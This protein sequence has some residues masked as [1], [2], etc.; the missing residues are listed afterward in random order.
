MTL[1]PGEAAEDAAGAVFLPLF[2]DILDGLGVTADFTAAEEVVVSARFLD[3]FIK[4]FARL[5]PFDAGFYER[6]YRDIAAAKAAGSLAD[7]RVHFINNGFRENRMPRAPL[8]DA[9]YYVATYPDL[10]GL[11]AADGEAGLL[12]HYIRHGR[13]ERRLAHKAAR[14]AAE[15]W[16]QFVPLSRQTLAH[17]SVAGAVVRAFRP[18]AIAADHTGFRGGPVLGDDTLDDL[19]RHRRRGRAVDQPPHEGTVTARLDGEYCYGGIAYEHFGH[20][21]AETVHRVLPARRFFACPRLL[22][23]GEL[24]GAA[25]TGFD[26]LART[27]QQALRLL[28]VAP[29][30]VTVVHDDRVVDC[31]HVAQQGAEL[32]GVPHA[33]YLAM[34]AEFTGARLDALWQGGEAPARVY[35][36]RSQLRDR[37]VLLGEAYLERQLAMEGWHIFHPEAH[38][39]A[40]QMQTYFRAETIIF[41]GGSSCHG[42]ELF[43]HRQLGDCFILPRWETQTDAYR[44][45]LA[46]RC[47]RLSSLPASCLLGSAVVDA[48]SGERQDQWGISLPQM[49][50]LAASLRGLGLAKLPYFSNEVF[51]RAALADFEVYLGLIGELGMAGLP[52]AGRDAIEA[53]VGEVRAL[54]S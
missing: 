25:P 45:V 47:R 8:F 26:S 27:Q 16:R 20:V 12:A 7:S 30:T 18:P 17:R 21:M 48:T 51:R 52:L 6:T 28:E 3:F 40:V 5:I 23:V 19:L 46:P 14:V 1:V 49:A 37:G 2:Q 54:L 43:G 39:L 53:L 38:E 10:A 24:S 22:F 15:R 36:S 11:A 4:E 31:L 35:V 50:P 44:A 32:N 34:L 9:A 42:T 13:D 33:A 41:A 29:E